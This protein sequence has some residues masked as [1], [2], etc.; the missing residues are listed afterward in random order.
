MKTVTPIVNKMRRAFLR[1]FGQLDC[2]VCGRKTAGK[3]C[4][5]V[6]GATFAKSGNDSGNG[7]VIRRC[8]DCGA[9][10]LPNDREPSVSGF[11]IL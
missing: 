4:D 3:L 8:D 7:E 1:G 5:H 10:W 6:A 9:A 2:L 11:D